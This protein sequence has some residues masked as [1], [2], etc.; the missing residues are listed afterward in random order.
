MA[1]WPTALS[2]M[3]FLKLDLRSHH[4]L[5]HAQTQRLVNLRQGIC[6]LFGSR[7]PVKSS[8]TQ[9][10]HLM[11]LKYRLSNRCHID[12]APLLFERRGSLNYCIVEGSAVGEDSEGKVASLVLE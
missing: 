8:W 1:G 3:L 4:P 12:D 2:R 5:G 11:V 9:R 7:T 10:V 6:H